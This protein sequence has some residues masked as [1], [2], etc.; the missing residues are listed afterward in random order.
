M[1]QPGQQCRLFFL[2]LAAWNADEAA[3]FGIPRKRAVGPLS[4]ATITE[5][6]RNFYEPLTLLNVVPLALNKYRVRFTAR[7]HDVATAWQSSKQSRARENTSLSQS[8]RL[9]DVRV[10]EKL[11]DGAL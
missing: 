3:K 9:I 5:F 6:Y 10:D 7:L 2:A 1:E 4:A 11:Y 8:K